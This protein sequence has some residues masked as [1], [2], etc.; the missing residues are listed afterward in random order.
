MPPEEAEIICGVKD[1]EPVLEQNPSFHYPGTIE[2]RV[3][4][5]KEDTFIMGGREGKKMGKE[6][7]EWN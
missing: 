4:R 7:L 3:Q 6:E 2:P 5:E 1:K